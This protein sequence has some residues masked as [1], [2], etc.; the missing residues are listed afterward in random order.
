MPGTSTSCVVG[1]KGGRTLFWQAA[2]ENDGFKEEMGASK[3]KKGMSSLPDGGRG[4]D[5]SR[6]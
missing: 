1:R 2:G 5:F 6:S 4:N 3:K